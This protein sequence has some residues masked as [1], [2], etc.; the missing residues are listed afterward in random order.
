[1]A[2][3]QNHFDAWQTIRA[4]GKWNFV[5]KRG[6]GFGT[7]M[8]VLTVLILPYLWHEPFDFAPESLAIKAVLD[9]AFGCGSGLILWSI[10]D[11]R[12]GNPPSNPGNEPQ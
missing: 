9:I 1:M 6:L 4:R 5:L 3:L 7:L 8:F 11:K 2:T 10:W 12:Y